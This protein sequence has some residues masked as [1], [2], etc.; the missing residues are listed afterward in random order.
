[1][2]DYFESENSEFVAVFGRRRVGKTFLIRETFETEFAF[3]FTGSV[4]S[5]LKNQLQNFNAALNKYGTD[6][7][8]FE[9]NWFKAFEQLSHLLEKLPNKNKKIIFLDEVPWMDTPRSGFLPALEYFWNG[10]A[11]SRKD[12]LLIVCG[13]ATSWMTNNLLKNRGGLH[14]RVTQKMYVAPFTLKECELYFKEKNIAMSRYQIAESYM[15]L[16]GVPF[17]LS[18]LDKNLSLAQNIDQL[19]FSPHG[20]LKDEFSNLYASLFKNSQNHIKIIEALSKKTKGMTQSELSDMTKISDGGGLVKILDELEQCGFIRKYHT[21]GQKK[22][23]L[24]QLIDFYTLFYYK[25]IK[26][27]AYFDEIF[28]LNS[29]DSAQHRSWSGFAFEQVCISHTRQMKK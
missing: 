2:S 14:N 28:W 23:Y 17:Y 4:N 3:Y 10:W 21:F 25:F 6:F 26:D 11:S 29:I 19:C 5:N 27:N 8:S 1:M 22:G 9:T 7:Y 12:I 24:Y 16:G 13:S 15:V 18:L 20:I